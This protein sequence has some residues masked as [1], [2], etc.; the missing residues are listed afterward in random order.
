MAFINIVDAPFTE[1]EKQKILAMRIERA[2]WGYPDI[3]QEDPVAHFQALVDRDM[4][5]IGEGGAGRTKYERNE[6]PLPFCNGEFED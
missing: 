5:L 1:E 6:S 4:D 3:V 2:E